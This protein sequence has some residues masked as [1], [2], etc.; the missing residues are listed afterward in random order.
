M[1]KLLFSLGTVGLGASALAAATASA[2]TV[3]LRLMETTDIHMHI[4]DYDYYTDSQ[5]VTVGLARTAAL[6]NAARNER[7]NSVLVDNGDLIQGNPW[8]IMW[9]RATC[10][11]SAKPTRPTKP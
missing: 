11:A 6:I 3:E 1:N 7:G 10:C 4:V 8:V 2:A 9:P 5:N